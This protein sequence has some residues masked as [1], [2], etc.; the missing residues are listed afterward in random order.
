[1]SI[2]SREFFAI[3]FSWQS[4]TATQIVS[5]NRLYSSAES[6]FKSNGFHCLFKQMRLN[7]ICVHKN[8]LEII[9]DN[10]LST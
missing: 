9:E 6:Y 1:M 7:N 2:M 4:P 5:S 10:I 3:E 8:C